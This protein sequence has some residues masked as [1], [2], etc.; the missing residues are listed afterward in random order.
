[1]KIGL[2]AQ[3][4]FFVPGPQFLNKKV[5]FLLALGI[6]SIFMEDVRHPGWLSARYRA[7]MAYIP[8]D[9]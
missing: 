1:M 4:D 9:A 2:P 8:G 6:G 5:K 3:P 7:K